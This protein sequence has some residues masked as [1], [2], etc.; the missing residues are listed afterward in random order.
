MIGILALAV[1]VISLLAIGIIILLGRTDKP[2]R[3]DPIDKESST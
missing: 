1:V 2:R 3:F